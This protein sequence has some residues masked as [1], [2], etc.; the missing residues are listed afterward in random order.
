MHFLLNQIGS[1]FYLDIQY[2]YKFIFVN[3]NEKVN[4]PLIKILVIL[5]Y[6]ILTK[7]REL[8]EKG[9]L[10]LTIAGA[11]Y[12]GRVAAVP[13]R[14]RLPPSFFLQTVRQLLPEPRSR[15]SRLHLQVPELPGLR[16]RGRTL[17]LGQRDRLR[18]RIEIL[19]VKFYYPWWILPDKHIFPAPFGSLFKAVQ[20]LM[21]DQ[22]KTHINLGQWR[23]L[24]CLVQAV[25]IRLY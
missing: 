5:V 14:G 11:D 16:P 4:Y 7:F 10:W 8:K 15:H 23:S 6:L 25:I 3:Q 19:T 21:L 12:G 9:T 13:G 17:Q 20:L 18:F 2:V 1:I 22:D 24:A